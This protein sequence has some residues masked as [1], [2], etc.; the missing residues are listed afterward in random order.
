MPPHPTTAA[1]GGFEK[2]LATMPAD[3]GDDDRHD[4]IHLLDRQQRAAGPTVTRLAATLPSR[5]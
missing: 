2:R 1:A 4:L 5:G 3:L